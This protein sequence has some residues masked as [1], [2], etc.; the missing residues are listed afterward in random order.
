EAKRQLNIEAITKK[1]LPLLEENSSPQDVK[2]D[3]ITNFFEKS[4]IVSDE[5]MQR[6]WSRV[7]AGEANKPG[8]FSR[9]TVNLLADMEKLDAEL[10]TNVY[11]FVWM[12]GL[13]GF[14]LVFYV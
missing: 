7:L 10:F 3:W 14:P 6:L 9:R 1:A 4:R 12:I 13:C 2:D 11:R 5:D 8:T